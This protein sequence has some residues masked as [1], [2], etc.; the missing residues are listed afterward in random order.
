ME[1]THCGMGKCAAYTVTI[2]PDGRVTKIGEGDIIVQSNPTPGPI[3]RERIEHHRVAGRDELDALARAVA[4]ARFF[5]RDGEGF[6]GP[7]TATETTP[8][9]HVVYTTKV[10]VCTDTAHVIL[11]I[12]LDGKA[13][14]VDDGRCESQPALQ[15]LEDL[16]DQIAESPR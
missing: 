15:A 16:V 13:H 6:L 7:R 9:G 11:R 2:A 4:G 14:E 3:D 5:E 12:S 1:R 10:A 8:D